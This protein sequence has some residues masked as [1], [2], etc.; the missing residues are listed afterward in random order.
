VV[1]IGDSEIAGAV[2]VDHITGGGLPAYRVAAVRQVGV[3]RSD[4]FFGFEEL[5]Y[6][7]RLTRAGFHLYA[8]GVRWQER[9]RVKRERGLLPSEEVSERRAA[10]TGLRITSST[11]RRYY[12]LRNL[13]FVLR[14]AGAD[15][16][17]LRVAVGRGV[18][19]PLVNLPLAP[20][21]AWNSLKSGARAGFDGWTGRLGTS[22]QPDVEA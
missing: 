20:R 13:V 17:A 14:E 4:L 9:K 3:M 8:D 10:T 2:P 6:G 1:R 16:T 12:S 18:L 21:D 22:V 11:W 19:K 15:A 5:E 7:L